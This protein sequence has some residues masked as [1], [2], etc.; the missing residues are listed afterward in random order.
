[1]RRIVKV[2]SALMVAALALGG[3]IVMA[4]PERQYE[5]MYEVATP[6]LLSKGV[7]W[8][9]RE[10]GADS[11]LVCFSLA[12]S[13]YNKS[14]SRQDK[15]LMVKANRGKWLVYFSYLY[16]YPKAYE[17][18]QK[19]I[20]ISEEAGVNKAKTHLS[21]GGM[22]HV[23]ADQSGSAD[24]YSKAMEEYSAAVREASA[25]DDIIMDFAF[26]NMIVLSRSRHSTAVLDKAWER[27]RKLGGENRLP[28]R[29]F[30][31]V[32]YRAVRGDSAAIAS[33]ENE[34]AL[35]PSDPEYMRLRF[36][37]LKMLAEI[38]LDRHAPDR[39]E[40]LTQR[41]LEHAV[42]HDMRDA[43]QEA[44]LLLS[45]ILRQRG[46][47]AGSN[48]QRDRYLRIK[49]ETMGAKQ[50]HRLDELRFLADLR[51]ADE[52]LALSKEKH[53]RQTIVIVALLVFCA[54]AVAFIWVVIHKNVRL[55]QAYNSLSY[56]FQA[57][58]AADDRERKLRRRIADIEQ[59]QAEQEPAPAPQPKYEGSS[60]GS[61]ERER[62]LSRLAELTADPVLI[63]SPGCSIGKLSES[64]GCNTKYLSQ[65]INDDYNCNFNTFI[66]E[67]RIKEACRRILAGGEWDRLTLEA[68]ANSVGFKSRSTF[69]QLFKQF[70]GMTPTEF[71]RQ[72]GR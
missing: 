66:N 34:I 7:A 64:I 50:L 44:R 33:M 51:A 22:L 2:I 25:A 18:L 54:M 71:K 49:E 42:R 56:R 16:D 31:R 58:L 47:I 32:L 57:T 52:Q 26:V 21:M 14:M 30:A 46:D 20:D 11:A 61:E 59:K 70:T 17:S 24:M 63:C 1:M 45:D 3:A 41:A 27:Y 60:L 39:A 12:A 65:I 37:G 68:I 15:E 9:N 19:A 36:I 53:R 72:A 4:Q 38:M 35:L 62:I 23:I 8:L 29:R 55:R 43:E 6:E 48:D 40:A 10:G 28:R 67:I 13:R 5:R 69:S